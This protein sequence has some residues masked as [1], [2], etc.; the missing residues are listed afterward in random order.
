MFL[1]LLLPLGKHVGTI[2]LE[3]DGQTDLRMDTYEAEK[4][5]TEHEKRSRLIS[6]GANLGRPRLF[7][8]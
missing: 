2:L 8:P 5:Q 7:P 3:I 6:L 1:V 4:K